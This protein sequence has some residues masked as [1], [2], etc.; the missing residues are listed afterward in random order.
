MRKLIGVTVL[1]AIALSL[2]RVAQAQRRATSAGMG[3]AEH[4][5]GVDIGVAYTKPSNVS[6]G[7]T[8]QTPFDVRFGIVPS[9]GNLMWEPRVTLNFSSVGGTTTYLFTPD[10]NVLISNSPGGHRRGM[11][12]T[13]GGGLVMGDF[14]VGT[15]TALE[16]NGGIGWRKPYGSAAWR[17]QVGVQWVSSSTKLGP[18]ADYIAIGG[19]I[20]ISLWH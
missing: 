3:G 18:F 12:F 6:G 7:I 17:Y 9:H 1:A 10:V 2:P 13:G 16:L 19:S 5:L 11:Y 20:G 15:G 8:I 14:G 4:E